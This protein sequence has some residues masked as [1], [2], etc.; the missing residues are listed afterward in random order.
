[1]NEQ[2][3][4]ASLPHEPYDEPPVTGARPN[5]ARR[6]G[7][8]LI[9]VGLLWLLFALPWRGFALF[10]GPTTV[11]DQTYPAH[12]L[13]M[14][15]GS[16]DVEVR[17]WSDSGIHVAVTQRGGSRNDISVNVDR[18]SDTLHIADSHRWFNWFGARDVQYTVLVPATARVQ[19][20]TTS[21]AIVVH[22]VAGRAGET[23]AMALHSVSGDIT[24]S[25]VAN[26][27]SASTTSGDLDL[28]RI[29]ND[30]SATTVNGD[31][32]LKGA[33]GALALQSTNGDITVRGADAKQLTV[34][35]TNGSIDFSG[36]LAP[37]SQNRVEAVNGDVTLALP[38]D[39]SFRLQATTVRGDLKLDDSFDAQRSQDSRTAL[40]ATVGSGAAMITVQT[41]SGDVEIEQQ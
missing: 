10:G 2:R 8:A 16:A 4:P 3:S 18:A 21:G 39:S 13:V 28:E 5:G 30:L 23:P 38:H 41:V 25:G 24:A 19:I 37:G 1:M 20:E 33:S 12:D 11:L 36:S 15:V 40:N 29:D 6:A 26:G 27:L 9:V 22:D 34:N 7:I 17:S 31:I 35:T 14:R 32:S